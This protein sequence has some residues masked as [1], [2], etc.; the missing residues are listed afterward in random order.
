MAKP[1]ALITGASRG[2]GRA[3]AERF[4]SA[5]HR[6]AGCSRK[7]PERP[8]DGCRHFCLDVSD[9]KAVKKLF[10]E[11]RKE[12]GGLDVLINNAGVAS[13]NHSLLTPLSTVERIFRT[14]VAGTFLFCREAA[15]LMKNAGRGRIVNLSTVAVPLRVEGESVYAASKAAVESLTQVLAREFAPFGVTVNAV[16]PTP[17]TEGGLIENVP[18]DK[19]DQLLARQA[20]PRMATFDDVYNVV[21]FFCREE[22]D[23]VT[24]QIVYLGGV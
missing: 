3:L 17:V 16:G 14:N 24:G 8:L 15:K 12:F 9:E 21:E 4:V 11:V 6:V 18:R 10:S 22:S 7:E 2:I 23:F 13:M 20:I 1:S 19:I 5:G